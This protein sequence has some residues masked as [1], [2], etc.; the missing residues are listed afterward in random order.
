MS[1]TYKI[2]NARDLMEEEYRELYPG[3]H[4][5]GETLD[6]A[7][8]ALAEA[9]SSSIGDAG[10]HASTSVEVRMHELGFTGVYVRAPRELIEALGLCEM[11]DRINRYMTW[12]FDD[13]M[14]EYRA[15][16]PQRDPAEYGP[17]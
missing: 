12:E 5:S 16:R 2:T 8:Q 11:I 15:G 4:P 3:E 10:C 9:V 13:R 17:T 1:E 14:R 7:A 6:Q